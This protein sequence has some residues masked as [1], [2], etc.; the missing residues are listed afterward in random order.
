MMHP[1]VEES[2]SLI[3]HNMPI[4]PLLYDFVNLS[5][6]SEVQPVKDR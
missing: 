4:A 5:V 6:T 2:K 1:T 3:M